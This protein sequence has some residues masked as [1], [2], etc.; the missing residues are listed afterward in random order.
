[1]PDH[2]HGAGGV[3]HALMAGGAE[4]HAGE[5]ASP[6][7]A[8]NELARA[9][10]VLEE[11]RGSLTLLDD[12]SDLHVRVFAEDFLDDRVEHLLGVSRGVIVLGKD[13]G[14]A[15]TERDLPGSDDVQAGPCIA[16]LFGRP[17]QGLLRLVRTIDPD[18]DPA[19]GLTGLAAHDAPFVFS[20][21]E[22][23]RPVS[24]EAE[25]PGRSCR[26]G[27]HGN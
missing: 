21:H 10:A 16:G 24:V 13:G 14:P 20:D 12:P 17:T 27:C 2:D 23:D 5:A 7:A 8:H 18:D 15:E 19:A 22:A 26:P 3:L 4:Q 11:R 6:A 25:D 1:V 9:L